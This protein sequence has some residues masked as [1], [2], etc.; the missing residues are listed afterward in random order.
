MGE[1]GGIGVRKNHRPVEKSVL[2][3]SSILDLGA[4]HATVGNQGR[5]KEDYPLL[6][7]PCHSYPFTVAHYSLKILASVF[8]PQC[9]PVELSMVQYDVNIN[10]YPSK[11]IASSLPNKIKRASQNVRL[12]SCQHPDNL[13][14]RR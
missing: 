13:K 5:G 7:L 14:V 8:C 11:V 3:L 12:C 1:R 6:A 9:M 4:P 2:P 10:K